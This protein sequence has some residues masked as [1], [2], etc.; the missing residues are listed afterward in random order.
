MRVAGGA[1]VNSEKI[2][3]VMQCAAGGVDTQKVKV[4]EFAAALR[5][6][7]AEAA[8]LR[9]QLAEAAGGHSP[10]QA[11]RQ[12]LQLSPRVLPSSVKAA[13]Q[14]KARARYSR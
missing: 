5:E 2:D 11:E 3:D 6:A 9:Q 13:A 10:G 8:E 14:Q 7:R 12:P 1:D 4:E